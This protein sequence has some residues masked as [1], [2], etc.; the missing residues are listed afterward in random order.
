MRAE[1]AIRGFLR[2]PMRR[3]LLAL[4]SLGELIRARLVT[5]LPARVY[6][7]D[8]GAV[9]TTAVSAAATPEQDEE[10]V[11]IGRMVEKV[12]RYLPFR[13]LCLQ[14]AI[15]VRRMLV[16]RGVPVSVCLGVSRHREDR[17]APALGRAAHAWV[18][19]GDRVVSGAG[20]LDRY[21]V[22]ARF[23]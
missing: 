7:R 3:R 22:V 10:A 23:G 2:A 13:A 6:T 9:V 11:R 5:L 14:Q 17:A 15:A 18:Q 8:F 16:R 4:E 21:A 20:E 19:V 12:A 1:R